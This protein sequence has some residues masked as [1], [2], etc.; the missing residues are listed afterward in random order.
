MSEGP[1]TSDEEASGSERVD[2][3][4]VNEA[5]AVEATRDQPPKID[6]TTPIQFLT[7]VGPKRAVLFEK[8]GIH[9]VGDLLWHVPR[10]LLDFSQITPPSKLEADVPTTVRGTVTDFDNRSLPGR[11]S[12]TSVLLECPPSPGS[13]EP[14]GYARGVWFNQPWQFNKLRT[15]N[16]L[17]SVVLMTGKPKLRSG[18]FEFS[19]PQ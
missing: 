18:H 2:E 7:G 9:E 4:P 15:A 3:T 12:L 17:R 19:H 13:E 14:V 11:R 10:T 5:G 1:V 8:L 6:F 16:E